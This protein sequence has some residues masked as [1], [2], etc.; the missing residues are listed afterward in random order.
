MAQ[1]T[2]PTDI[3]GINAGA[4]STLVGT[5]NTAIATRIIA[6]LATNDLLVDSD[7]KLLLSAMQNF[8]NN[9]TSVTGTLGF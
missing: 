8:I 3:Y 6:A 4:A 2:N 5:S 1:N 9:G 7:R